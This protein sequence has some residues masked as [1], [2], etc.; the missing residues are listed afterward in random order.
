[1]QNHRNRPKQKLTR[2]NLSVAKKLANPIITFG[3]MA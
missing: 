1:M 2:H 3:A